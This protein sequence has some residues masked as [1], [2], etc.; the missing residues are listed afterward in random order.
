MAKRRIGFS[1]GDEDEYEGR[2]EIARTRSNK[3]ATPNCPL[4]GSISASTTGS[5]EW[6]CRFH[7]RE[8]PKF[9]ITDRERMELQDAQAEMIEENSYGAMVRAAEENRK[10]APASSQR[11]NR[12]ADFLGNFNE[13]TK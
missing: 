3:C 12:A 13:V 5:S 10:K 8:Q 7:F 11:K 6:F 1:G 4:P 2:K 9:P